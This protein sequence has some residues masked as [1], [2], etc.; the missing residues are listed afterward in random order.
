MVGTIVDHGRYHEALGRA[1]K[2]EDDGG[3]DGWARARAKGKIKSEGESEGD[4]L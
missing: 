3:D 2:D 4:I 1:R